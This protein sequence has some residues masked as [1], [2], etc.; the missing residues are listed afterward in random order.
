VGHHCILIIILARD[1]FGIFVEVA[2]R[3]Y[4]A[5]DIFPIFLYTG[6]TMMMQL[7]HGF[8]VQKGVHVSGWTGFWKK[9]NDTIPPQAVSLATSR[10]RVV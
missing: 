2:L 4:I 5:Q 1:P 10:L 3:G 6:L 7:I 9:E 8:H